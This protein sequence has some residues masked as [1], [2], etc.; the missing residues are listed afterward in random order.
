[1]RKVLL[2]S[3]IAMVLAAP[4]FAA[5]NSHTNQA[6]GTSSQAASSSNRTTPNE[7]IQVTSAD[8]LVGRDVR[9]KDGKRAGEIVGLVLDLPRGEVIYALVGSG[10]D[11]NI[12]DDRIAV[13]FR[14][15]QTPLSNTDDPV[16]INQDLSRIQGGARVAE[17]RFADLQRP[18]RLKQIYGAYG[19]EM[20]YGFVVPPS[21]EGDLHPYRYVLVRPDLLAKLGRSTKAR[22]QDIR[23]SDVQRANGD[24]LGKIDQVMIDPSSGRIAYLLLSSGG[25]LG[26]GN[27]WLPVPPEAVSWSQDKDAYVLMDKNVK[28]AAIQVLHKTDLPARVERSQLEALYQRFNLKPYWETGSTPNQG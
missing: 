17:D 26:I 4:A 25:F 22:A 28:P 8:H 12:G 13:P 7:W 27:D 15:L 3:A 1:M 23:G 20:P 2:S 16:A 11:L 19:I 9:S 14:A 21:T 5:D 24:T 6:N 10:G 18:D